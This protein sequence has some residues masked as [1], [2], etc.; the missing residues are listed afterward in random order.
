MA[1]GPARR[2]EALRAELAEQHLDAVVV[3]GAANIRYLT[4]F[5]GSAAHLVVS[6]GRTVLVTDFRYAGQAPAEVGREVDVRIER[7]S[8][9]NGLRQSIGAL[10]IRRLGIDR[11]RVTL[12]AWEEFRQVTA[13]ELVPVSG[14]VERLRVTKDPEEIEA[15][16]DA[17]RLAGEALASVVDFIRPGRTELEVA[18]ELEA[19]LRRRG[20][21]WHPFQSIVAAGP[22]SALPHARSSE[23]PIGVGE[24][25]VVDFGAQVRGYCSDI[26]R[27][28]VVGARA[29]QRQRDTY[30]VVREA[31]TR[32]RGAL[33]AGLTG[34]EGDSLAREVIARAGMG[35]AFG[36]SLGHGLG[37]EVHEDPRLSQTS[38]TP[39]PA[40][41][42]VTVEP[43]VYFDGW[44]G[45]RIEDDLV[46]VDGGAECLSDGRTDLVELT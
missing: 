12:A 7:S 9:W 3:A 27:T 42:V 2:R 28:F 39:L 26:T 41:A 36:H 18:A 6:A 15:I 43:G 1:D 16:R 10:G 5:T 17:A 23:R 46:L 8:L 11:S 32:A 14:L 33:R 19:A 45:V 24:F 29:D 20:S 30:G 38:E 22:R 25:L 21:E 13:V 31:Q 44:G 37:L 35:E 40:G 4:G 34:R